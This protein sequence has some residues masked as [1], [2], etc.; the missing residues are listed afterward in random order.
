MEEYGQPTLAER[1]EPLKKFYPLIILLIVVAAVFFVYQ[2]VIPSFVAVTQLTVEV[3]E[4]DTNIDI[5]DTNDEPIRVMIGETTSTSGTPLAVRAGTI[6]VSVNDEDAQTLGYEISSVPVEIK[7]WEGSK[8]ETI[9]LAKIMPLEI[10]VPPVIIAPQG[11]KIEVPITVTNTGND[12]Q[13]VSLVLTGLPSTPEGLSEQSISAGDNKTFRARITIASTSGADKTKQTKANARIKRTNIATDFELK[14]VPK[15]QYSISPSDQITCGAEASCQKLITIT[16]SMDSE[17]PV[18]IT[19]TSEVTPLGIATSDSRALVTVP[20]S[21]SYKFG[22]SIKE[23]TAFGWIYF[24]A[25]TEGC[26]T[27]QIAIVKQQ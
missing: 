24:H 23:P 10:S 5:R 17:L 22:V 16:N 13:N 19:W 7:P 14:S 12:K 27:K 3:Q 25:I 26:A 21:G 20:A 15:V 8:T 9:T 1:L 18:I 2:Y 11:C 4:M 6:Q